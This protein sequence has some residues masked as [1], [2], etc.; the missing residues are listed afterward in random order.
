MEMN[1]NGSWS[2]WSVAR[3]I[4]FIMLLPIFAFS[5]F[6]TTWTSSYL[7]LDEDWR[8]EIVF[9]PES[10]T[11]PDQ[12]YDVD[13]FIYAFKCEPIMTAVCL[14]S[15]LLLMG[16]IIYWIGKITLHIIRR[17]IS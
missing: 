13:K 15:F 2:P 14:L 16:L 3:L 7:M 9:T 6:A 10:V 17:I 12:I 8:N 11:E 5:F 1:R 4:L